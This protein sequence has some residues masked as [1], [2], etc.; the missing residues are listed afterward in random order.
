MKV[1]SVARRA[2][3]DKRT[4]YD[5]VSSKEDLL[6]LVFADYLPSMLGKIRQARDSEQDPK[7]QLASMLQVHSELLSNNPH[8]VLFH[9][10]ELRHLSS[11]DQAAVYSLINDI[12]HEYERVF[13]ILENRE[14]LPTSDAV[15]NASSA[16]TM[17]DMIGLHRFH[18]KTRTANEIANHIVR[19]LLG[20]HGTISEESSEAE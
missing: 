9:Y 14:Q 4:L 18:L 20:G 7:D 2:G 17:L 11:D 3:I 1:E 10:R 12:H 6:L 15:L 5:Y 8:F 13:I 19:V 16:L